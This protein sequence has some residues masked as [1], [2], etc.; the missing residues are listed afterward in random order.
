MRKLSLG[1]ILLFLLQIGVSAP[2]GSSDPKQASGKAK[3]K[4]ASGKFP[5]M[6][7]QSMGDE[8]V[9]FFG[10][11]TGKE[12]MEEKTGSVAGA[13]AA[14]AKALTGQLG[15]KSTVPSAGKSAP[16]PPPPVP[17][18]AVSPIRQEIQKILEL[19]RRIQN[20]QGGRSVQ[21]QSVQEQARIH[22]KILNGLEA[23][24]K[25]TASQRIPGKNFLLAQEKLRDGR[26][27]VQDGTQVSGKLLAVPVGTAAKTVSKPV[28]KAANKPAATTPPT[29][30]AKAKTATS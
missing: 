3:S 27:D 5:A 13:G 4:E 21:A 12:L 29:I 20:V 9:K 22:Q 2:Q 25:K 18:T 26:Q 7:P 17:H 11:K 16:I 15:A 19:N 24:Q 28:A 10:R 14:A 23:S 8:I 1:F 30:A 6:T